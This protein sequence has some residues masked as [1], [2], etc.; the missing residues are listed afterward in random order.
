MAQ[1][2]EVVHPEGRLYTCIF[3]SLPCFFNSG[4]CVV[5][6][7]DIEAFLSKVD[8]VFPCAA[9]EVNGAAWRDA[10]AF[11]QRHEFL[12]RADVPRSAEIAVE[13]FVEALRDHGFTPGRPSVEQITKCRHMQ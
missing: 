4:F 8:G 13:N 10:P 6:A 3:C 1:V 11:H 2:R 9:A 5:H 7:S 12:T